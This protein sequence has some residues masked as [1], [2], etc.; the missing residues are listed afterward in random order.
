MAT[1]S[2]TRSSYFNE[3]APEKIAV[4][5][6]GLL[7]H[8]PDEYCPQKPEFSSG[9]LLELPC[10]ELFQGNTPRLRLGVLRELLPDWVRLPEETDP[11][12]SVILPAGW[13]ALYFQVV[14]RRGDPHVASEQ[15]MPPNEV[16]ARAEKSA[17][18]PS[19]TTTL[20]AEP[21]P[22]PTSAGTGEKKQGFFASLPIFKRQESEAGIVET[23]APAQEKLVAPEHALTLEPLWKLDAADQLSDPTALQ[24]LFMTEE[25]LTLERVISLAGTLP[26]LR[27][28]VLAHGDRVVC[29][30]NS[31]AGIDLRTLSTQATVM[32]S[33]IRESSLQMG[34]GAVPAVTLH[35]EQGTLSFLHQGELCLLVLHADRG[36]L[37]GVSERLQKMLTHLVTAKA[38]PN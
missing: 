23:S 36:F 29:A 17:V 2:S 35:C 26:G 15:N 33:Q 20:P 4:P 38:L 16:E 27:A 10:A 25:K 19:C 31:P 22:V 11:E 30:S 13:L 3:V 37:P 14:T 1:F 34:L 7:A 8:L 5:L 24:A 21:A 32:L 28:C 6:N 18:A 9:R 12:Q